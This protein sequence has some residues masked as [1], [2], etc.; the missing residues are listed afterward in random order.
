MML[1]PSASA[2]STAAI[3]TKDG[4]VVANIGDSRLYYVTDTEI[5][6]ITT[7][8]SVVQEM[9]ERGEITRNDARHHPSK[10]LITRALGAS[11]HEPPDVFFI[12]MKEGESILLCSDGLTEV[13]LDS[14]IQYQLITG[15]SVR[16]S[17]EI[18]VNMALERGAPDNVTAVVLRK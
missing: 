7:D 13:V 12:K 2:R 11:L 10:N 16:E 18:L 9:V 4:E 5:S 3:S 6:Q 17:C 8:H 15:T 14:E 1:T